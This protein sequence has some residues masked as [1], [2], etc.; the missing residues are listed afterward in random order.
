MNKELYN[1]YIND[2]SYRENYRRELNRDLAKEFSEQKLSDN[3]RLIR[4]FEILTDAEVAHIH[5]FEKIVML[6]TV[7][8]I[9]DCFTKEEWEERRKNHFIHESGYVSNLCPNYAKI[10]S[11]GLLAARESA[12]EYG[13]RAIDAI[14]KLSDKYLDKAREVGRSDIVDILTRVPRYSARTLREALQFFRIL[15]FSL[16]LEGDYHNTVGRFDVYMYPYFKADIENG[17]LTMES[18]KELIED[19]FISFNKDSDLYFGVQQ[20]DN[21]QSLVLGGKTADGGE[22]FNELSE[23]CLTVSEELKLI[24]PKINLRVNKDT[25]LS[26]YEKCTK[27]TRAGLGFPQY[28][29]DDV[30]IPGLLRL[31]YDYE[32]AVN[33]AMA[34]CWEF[35]IPG[36][37][38]DI[39]NIGGVNFP[40]VVDR[41]IRK[42]ITQANSFDE[43]MLAVKE[44]IR[45]ECDRILEGIHDVLFTPSHVMDLLRDGKKY[46]NFGIHG[47]GIASGADALAAVKKFVFEDKSV[48]PERLISALDNDFS[49]DP[50]L[51]HK[52]RYEAPKMGHAD[53][54][55]DSLGGELLS[56][57]ADALEGR[58]NCLG[59]VV[60]A[61]TGTA[62]FYLW[63]AT[64][65]GATADGRR[66]GEPF[67]TNF[68]PNLFAKIPGPVSVI[69]S[70]TSFDM[71]R[72]V[73]GGPLTLE[74]A[75]S[76]FRSEESITKVAALIKYFISRGGH[77]L[78][79]NAV[80]LDT[81][82]A[83]QKDP[84]LYKNLV[85]R[86]WGWSAY[87]VELDKEFQDHVM[88]RQ[89]YTV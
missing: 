20:G 7:K 60:R 30:V 1:F 16:W 45:S 10:I 46:N 68:S 80:N 88:A 87:F 2:R 3:E 64:E 15:H 47:S 37:G 62:M 14:L 89:E 44:E 12:D 31:G 24:D 76:V 71:T 83:A 32:D 69:E 41:A 42:T 28:S 27:L 86:I 21:G 78:Q 73:N 13:K 65:V 58:R 36:V 63:H 50:E 38:N 8:N 82:R 55:A 33:Y 34:A 5:D 85:V 67:G 66:R 77:Q 81:M 72:N 52:L 23:I 84:M 6:R 17:T 49:N 53:L 40:L 54:Y 43:V 75:S 26:V 29:N 19:F 59:G 11:S 48:D 22:A 61:G 25:P 51:L 35:I 57:F 79:L 74:F 18:A 70:F 39:A 56:A 4:R 9:P